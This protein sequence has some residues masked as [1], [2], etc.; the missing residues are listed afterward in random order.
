[1]K[2][3]LIIF[4]LFSSVLFFN[5]CEKDVAPTDTTPST[6]GEFIQTLFG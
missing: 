1:M 4:A 3:S 6:V 2:N 5:G